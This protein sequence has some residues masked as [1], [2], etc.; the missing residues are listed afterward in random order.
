MSAKTRSNKLAVQR[1]EPTALRPIAAAG[2]DDSTSVKHRMDGVR[3]DGTA[4]KWGCGR[5]MDLLDI[6]AESVSAIKLNLR[7][8]EMTVSGVPC[9]REAI[10]LTN[11]R[12]QSEPTSQ[13]RI[14]TAYVGREPP[15]PWVRT[16][17]LVSRIM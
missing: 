14:G 11:G 17:R 13:H 8:V 5:L 10:N 6:A 7:R 9:R 16:G 12:L 3:A 2:D 1:L 4:L 15:F